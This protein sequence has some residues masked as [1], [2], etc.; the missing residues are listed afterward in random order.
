[1]Q[2]LLSV[3]YLLMHDTLILDNVTILNANN[4]ESRVKRSKSILILRPAQER[5]QEACAGKIQECLTFQFAFMNMK[6]KPFH[7][8]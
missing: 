4:T 3:L 7:I 6:Q 2:N 5:N 1:M 8:L